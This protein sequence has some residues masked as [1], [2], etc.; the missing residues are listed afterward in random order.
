MENNFFYYRMRH[1]RDAI[2][3]TRHCNDR[4]ASACLCSLTLPVN[5][6]FR[7]HQ[8]PTEQTSGPSRRPHM[9]VATDI[10]S[11]LT[12]L[13]LSSTNWRRPTAVHCCSIGVRRPMPRTCHASVNSPALVSHSNLRLL[14]LG[15]SSLLSKTPVHIICFDS[16][17][18]TYL[19]DA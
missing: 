4:R 11:Y 16:I 18:H 6:T 7:S 8:S 2:R 17:G 5:V 12:S 14:C 19:T 1:D 13:E 3:P 10:P 9:P 15:S